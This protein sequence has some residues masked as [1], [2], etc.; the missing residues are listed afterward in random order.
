MTG[1][2][3]RDAQI[4]I[5][6]KSIHFWA[7][8]VVGI[9]ACHLSVLAVRGEK[10]T[11]SARDFFAAGAVRFGAAGPVQGCW[12]EGRPARCGGKRTAPARPIVRGKRLP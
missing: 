11:G 8:S 3:N 10:A 6:R 4:I 7:V 1:G 12:F 5:Q 2:I 9:D